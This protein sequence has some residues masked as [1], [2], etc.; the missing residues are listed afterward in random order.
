MPGRALLVGGMK[1][2]LQQE[3]VCYLCGRTYNLEKHHIFGG[4]ANRRISE[5]QGLWVWLCGDTCHRGTDGAQYD[6]DKNIMLKMDA[7]TAFEKT[8]SH[9]EWMKIIGRNYL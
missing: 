8:H 7:Q 2:I 9:N 1:S 5:S 6:R 4:V 3:K